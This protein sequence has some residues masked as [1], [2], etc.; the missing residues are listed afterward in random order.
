MNY[1]EVRRA[2]S[3]LNIL[4]SVE[5]LSPTEILE[6]AVKREGLIT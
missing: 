1:C 5:C 3:L 2:L 4:P 6:G